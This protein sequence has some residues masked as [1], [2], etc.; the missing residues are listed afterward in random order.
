LLGVQDSRFNPQVKLKN[1]VKLL[2]KKIE[3]EEV[4]SDSR[5]ESYES[6]NAEENSNQE[7]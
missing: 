4:G 6:V 1:F 5:N 2:A 3:G 7:F